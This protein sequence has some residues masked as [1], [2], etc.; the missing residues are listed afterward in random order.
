MSPQDGM[1]AALM[2]V[3]NAT[4][5]SS[6]KDEKFKIKDKSKEPKEK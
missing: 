2:T 5:N 4:K 6:K 3:I 1:I